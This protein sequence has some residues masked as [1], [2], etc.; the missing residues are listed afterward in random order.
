MNR[1]DFLKALLSL[2]LLSRF[3]KSETAEALPAK[4]EIDSSVTSLTDT[5]NSSVTLTWYNPDG[6]T[7]TWTYD[8]R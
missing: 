8:G 1:S 6:S 5:S 3:R 7:Q 4:I 2:P